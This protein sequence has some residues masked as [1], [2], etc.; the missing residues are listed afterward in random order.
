MRNFLGEATLVDRSIDTAVV[1]CCTGVAASLDER[2]VPTD[3]CLACCNIVVLHVFVVLVLVVL[4]FVVLAVELNEFVLDIV[5]SSLVMLRVSNLYAR[6]GL[7]V[8]TSASHL[9]LK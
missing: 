2:H 4:A 9:S 6:E 8:G 3:R 5:P 7:V 1:V